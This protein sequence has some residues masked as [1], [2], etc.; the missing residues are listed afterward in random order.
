MYPSD[1]KKRLRNGELCL[2]TG[3]FSREPYVAAA[4]FQTRP[5]WVW[6][7]QEHEPWG[8]ESIGPIC[9]MA[10]QAGVAGVIRVAWNDPGDIKK[11]YDVGAVGV[12]VPQVDTPQEAKDSVRFAK[13][14]PIGERG[15]APWFGGM[16]GLTQDDVIKH[17]NDETLL[18][19]QMESVEAYEN[20]DEILALEHFDVLL[21]G[22]TDLSASLGFPGKIHHPK[23]EKIMLEMADRVRG[24]G[25]ALG[26]TFGDPEDCRR[27]IEVGYRF[28][29]V[30][31]VLGLGTQGSVRYFAEFRAA[32]DTPSARRKAAAWM[33]G[34]GRRR[35]K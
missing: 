17:A 10:R 4:V 20:V 21:V 1:I 14:P 7:D 22:P 12:M 18:I 3:M 24:T 2:G 34:S 6:I 8:T 16:M 28:M 13:Y 25:K 27:W 23:V 32:F 29:N 19:I 11:A 5:D 31:S 26:T 9:V 30:S 35:G 33:G 15:I